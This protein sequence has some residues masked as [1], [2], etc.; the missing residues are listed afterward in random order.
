MPGDQ[1]KNRH[2]DQLLLAEAILLF[3]GLDEPGQQVICRLSTAL[4]NDV[5][6]ILGQLRR[7][8]VG[9]FIV[10]SV[11]SPLIAAIKALDHV[12]S[13]ARSGREF[14]AARR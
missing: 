8:L 13:F 9:R 3:P 6:Q 14:P 7:R 2:G 11:T 5:R 10:C 4:G 1:Q 12:R